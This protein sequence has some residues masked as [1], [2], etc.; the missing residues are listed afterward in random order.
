[1][2]FGT[3]NTADRRVKRTQRLIFEAFA[4]LVQS[5]RFDEIK[6]LDIINQADVGKSTFYEHFKDKNDVLEQSLAAPLSII[7]SVLCGQSDSW[8]M[9]GI[10]N[11][12]W[13]NRTL[14]RVILT[15]PTRAVA[16]KCLLDLIV[17]EIC[18]NEGHGSNAKTT[19][20][21]IFLSAGF[22]ALLN[23]WLTGK[24]AVNT[25]QFTRIASDLTAP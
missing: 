16:E 13:T 2:T 8:S 1:M 22:I 23:D 17:T 4:E 9:E 24:L 12:F 3:N 11:H 14:G 7:A 19:A 25:K 5:R 15:H 20:R 10:L 18:Q 21:A 6:T